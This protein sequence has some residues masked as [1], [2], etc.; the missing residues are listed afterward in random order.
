MITNKIRA[1]KKRPTGSDVN[2]R[3][4]PH[5]QRN[6]QE[7]DESIERLD[8]VDVLCGEPG[9]RLRRPQVKTGRYIGKGNGMHGE[10][11]NIRRD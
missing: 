8:N 6:Y 4:T 7:R 9:R 5:H 3:K 11:A 10:V 1:L 2:E